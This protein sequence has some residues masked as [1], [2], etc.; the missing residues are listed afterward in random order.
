MANQVVI[1]H[2][3]QNKATTILEGVN[4][5][6]P[7]ALSIGKLR[8]IT[9]ARVN[10]QQSQGLDLPG[11]YSAPNALTQA[12]LR[13]QTIKN[14]NK[15]PVL[16]ACT[17]TSIIQSLMDMVVQGLSPAKN[18]CYFIAYGNELQ[19]QRSYFGTAA[20]VKRLD[21]VKK[22]RAEVVHEGDEFEIGSDEDMELVVKKFV[23]K[24][25]NISKPIIGAF[26]LIKTDEGNSYT[27][28]NMDEIKQSW[29]QTRQKNNKV[30]QNFSQEMAKRT[31]LNRAAKL[32]INTSDDSDLL[33][34]AIN[35]TTSNE[36]DD[37][38]RDVTP[39]KEEQ[40]TQE[41]L[42][43][44]EKSQAE[45]AKKE[46]PADDHSSSAEGEQEELF[47]DGTITPDPAK[48]NA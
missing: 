41:L 9:D 22:V 12:F 40:T 46:E 21:G 34:G 8:T 32:F 6:Q 38:P 15:Q 24:F 29:S 42:D 37:E 13:L 31:V 48:V 43:G 19:M 23:P 35:D 17:P 36:F 3:L 7:G 44:F 10:K 14:S 33:T 30:Q 47:K 5:N 26:A 20:A 4:L 28:M 27:V 16:Q 45:L 18:Q 1:D 39:T 25:E 11:S 2:E